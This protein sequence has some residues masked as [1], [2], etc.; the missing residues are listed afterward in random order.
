MSN[1]SLILV[2]NAGSTSLKYK[3][4]D[5]KLKVIQQGRYNQLSEKAD[6]HLGAF[7]KILREIGDLTFSAN[8]DQ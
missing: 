8:P 5:G 7:R 4:F 3:L 2:L 6:S 1:N